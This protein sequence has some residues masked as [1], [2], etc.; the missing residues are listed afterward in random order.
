MTTQTTYQITLPR[1]LT[2]DPASLTPGKTAEERQRNEVRTLRYM[3]EFLEG[4][5]FETEPGVLSHS[6]FACRDWH[7]QEIA[8]YFAYNEFEE[9]AVMTLHVTQ[10]GQTLSH[11]DALTL[12][13]QIAAETD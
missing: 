5:G 3:Q 2:E 12:L 7:E 11:E 10:D 4:L 13:R 9:C 1:I 6:V 8:A